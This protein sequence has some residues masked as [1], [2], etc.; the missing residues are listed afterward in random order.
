MP[1]RND[2]VLRACAVNV[3]YTLAKYQNDSVLEQ[4]VLNA[5]KNLGASSTATTLAVPAVVKSR[6]AGDKN[7]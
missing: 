7:V 3:D 4:A 5:E 1:S 6:V 2:L